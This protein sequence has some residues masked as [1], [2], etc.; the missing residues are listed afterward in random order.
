LVVTPLTVG[1]R[2]TILPVWPVP[3]V[4]MATGEIDRTRFIS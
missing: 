2:S 1:R 4:P 3:V